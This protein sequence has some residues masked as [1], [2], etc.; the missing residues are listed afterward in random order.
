MGPKFYTQN[1]YTELS[2]AAQCWL[3]TTT[4]LIWGIILIFIKKKEKRLEKGIDAV[5][6]SAGDYTVVA[7]F[8]WYRY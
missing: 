7:Q 5:T 3:G 6:K 2:F 1:E 4:V 8:F